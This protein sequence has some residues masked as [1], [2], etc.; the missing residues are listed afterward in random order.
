M[1]N[2]FGYPTFQR[3]FGSYVRTLPYYDFSLTNEWFSIRNKILGNSPELGKPVF[4]TAPTPV[5]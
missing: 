2:F 1:S 5:W 3:K 4:R